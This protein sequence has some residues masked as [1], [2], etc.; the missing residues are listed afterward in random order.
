MVKILKDPYDD[1]L[2]IVAKIS[3]KV[4]NS[5]C[6]GETLTPLW[7]EPWVMHPESPYE[8]FH[9]REIIRKRVTS[10]VVEPLC[11]L[12]PTTEAWSVTKSILFPMCGSEINCTHSVEHTWVESGVCMHL[13]GNS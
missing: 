3:L 7:V 9:N 13:V 4:V 5:Q 12:I 2:W 11:K 1:L 8:S 10:D 6:G